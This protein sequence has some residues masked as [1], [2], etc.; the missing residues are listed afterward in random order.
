MAKICSA[1]KPR[2]VI[3]ISEQEMSQM[4][5]RAKATGLKTPHQWAGMILRQKLAAS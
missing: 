5:A 2:L 1:T 3:Y 4:K